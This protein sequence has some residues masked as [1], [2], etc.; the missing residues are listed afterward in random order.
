MAGCQARSSAG[1]T[2][3]IAP[4]PMS[5]ATAVAWQMQCNVC[6]RCMFVSVLS[7][8]QAGAGGQGGQGGCSVPVATMTTNL[9]AAFMP[10]VRVVPW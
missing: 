1:A 7:S 9:P 8:V 4:L 2:G 10:G 6:T 5:A 3:E